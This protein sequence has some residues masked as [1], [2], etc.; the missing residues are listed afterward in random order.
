M[1]RP[2]LATLVLAAAAV[3]PRA[4]AP[5]DPPQQP[6]VFKA[7]VELVRLDIRVVDDH[8]LP[9]KDLRPEEIRITEGGTP[10]PV[11]LFQHVAEPEGS[12]LEV[13]RRTIGAEV[14]TNQGAPRGHLYL[15]VF[16]QSHIAAGNEQ[17]ARQAVDRFL[18][19]RVKPGD[20]VA[21]YALPGPGPQLPL[22]SN[23]NLAIA[24]L[25]KV[26]GSLDREGMALGAPMGIFEAFQITRGDINALQRFLDRVATNSAAGGDA[27]T[28]GTISPVSAL[29]AGNESVRVAKENARTIVERADVEARAFLMELS[30]VIRE[31]AQIEGRKTVILVSEGFFTDNL[32]VD[33]ERVAAAAAES[34]AVI[35]SMDVNR[36]GVD[37]NADSPTGAG[38][39]QEVQSRLDALTTLSNDSSGEVLLDAGS[40]MDEALSRVADSSQDYYIVGFQASE[41]A[42]GERREYRRI[43]VSVVRRGAKVETRTGYALRAAITQADRRQ[44]IDVALGAPFPQ[45]GLPLEMT[46]YVLRGTSPGVQRVVLSLQAD[47]PV[48]ANDRTSADVV[49]VTRNARD[50]R[51]VAS[52]TDTMPLPRV[53]PPGRTT[54]QGQFRVQFDA[55][56]GDYLLRVA[57]REPGGTTG[58][59]DRRFEIRPLDGVDVTASDL[60]IGR[61]TETLPVRAR[62]YAS[63]GLLAA[64]EVYARSPVELESVDVTLD[65]VPLNG[66]SAVRSVKADLQDIRPVGNGAGRTA[67]AGVPLDGVPP[68]DYLARATL[69]SRG[70]TVISVVRQFELSAADPPAA[71]A[72]ASTVQ[73]VT[74]LLILSGDLAR[75]FVTAIGA[76]AGS[77]LQLKRAADHAV[78][79]TWPE[80]SRLLAQPSSSQ[81]F[82]YQSLRGLA[83]FASERYDEAAVALEGALLVQPKSAPAA[84]FLGWVR[85]LG[86]KPAEAV[87]AWRNAILNDPQMVSG[88]L[89]LAEAYRRANHPELAEQV[90]SEGIRLNPASAELKAKLAEGGRK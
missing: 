67:Q 36:R 8:G 69:R 5:Q 77:N 17:R 79:G 55:P 13:A 85:S 4:A 29:D 56:A 84:F 18:R 35:Y 86:G 14:S 31:L 54:A 63:E 68:G 53:V 52:G 89:A 50:G 57:V 70:E 11:V 80:V 51:V 15:I 90:L 25:P 60:I 64:L 42:L 20:R 30:D 38:P 73:R 74:P 12:Y 65:I 87:T 26:R 66:E 59:V 72:P 71:T 40:R 43:S 44:S 76:S 48:A 83:L 10:R 32:R 47:L 41:A 61:R 9:I 27:V 82:G 46:T 49:F 39:A 75:Q 7:G 37:L 19:T 6:P 22:S 33:V 78:Q 2:W 24:E 1:L 88:Y 16:D 62:C 21:L 23:T 34:Y 58:T 81:P 3:S 45:Q 28:R